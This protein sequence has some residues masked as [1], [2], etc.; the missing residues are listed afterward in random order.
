M[1]TE[2]PVK[3]FFNARIISMSD[4]VGIVNAMVIE[5]GKIQAVGDYDQICN[6]YGQHGNIQ[7]IDV[8]GKSIIPGLIDAHCHFT[9]G[10]FSSLW[11]DFSKGNIANLANIPGTG[12]IRGRQPPHWGDHLSL[13]DLDKLTPNRPAIIVEQGYHGCALNS[14]AR[15]MLINGNEG[16]HFNNLLRRPETMAKGTLTDL[17]DILSRP[18]ENSSAVFETAMGWAEN[19]SRDWFQR[20]NYNLLIDLLEHHSL[21]FI[22]KGITCVCDA[23]VTPQMQFLLQDADIR[24]KLPLEVIMLV[25]GKHGFYESPIERLEKRPSENFIKAIKIFI[26]GGRQSLI[27]HPSGKMEG[28]QHYDYLEIAEW[29]QKTSNVGLKL[30][31]HAMGNGAT[32]LIL[33]AYQWAAQ[34]SDISP[35]NIRIEHAALLTEKL[36]SRLSDSRIGIVTQPHW[37]K[38]LG[39]H[40]IKAPYTNIK[41]MP[42]KSLIAAGVPLAGSSDCTDGPIS[43]P[44]ESMKLAITREVSDGVCLDS[45][46]IVSPLEVL[47]MY[48]KDAA[49]LCDVLHDRGTLDVGKRADFVI[50]DGDPLY[51]DDIIHDRLSIISTYISG[52][53][54]MNPER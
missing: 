54:F 16:D 12:W 46:E 17:P 36:I 33:D 40:W 21:Q 26:D 28:L 37:I 41:F 3:I 24:G 34:N 23:A 8:N 14:Y 43:S 42:L 48:T 10:A 29:I 13:Q 30:A 18:K 9:I 45:E 6:I 5:N 51:T 15:T 38:W 31:C 27:E 19:E 39:R 25:V 35:D 49:L 11:H 32:K 4:N 20:E 52:Q 1:I 53:P 2:K 22:H 44:F 7:W 50:L 47:K